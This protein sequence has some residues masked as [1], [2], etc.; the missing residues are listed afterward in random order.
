MVGISRVQVRGAIG[1][2]R[3]GNIAARGYAIADSRAVVRSLFLSSAVRMELLPTLRRGR[4]FDELVALTGSVRPERLQAWLDIGVVLGELGKRDGCY[5]IRGRRARAIA[6]GDALLRAHY[7][8]MLDYQVG[9]YADLASLLQSGVGEGRADLDEYADDIARVSQAATPFLASYVT[10]LIGDERPAR[11]LDVGCGTAI[12]ST[13]AVAADPCVRV[14]GIDLSEGVIESARADL[15]R[16]GLETRI[17]LHAG[18]IR[19]WTPPPSTRY[20]IILLLNNIYYFP[21]DERAALYR[22]LGGLLSGNG[23][24]VVATL[25]AP[26]SIAAAHLNFMLVCQA[27]H[28]ALPRHRELETDLA[29]AGYLVTGSQLIVPTEPFVAVTAQWNRS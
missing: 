7:R 5:R 11:V 17:R 9:P 2:L 28:A 29:A 14:D 26:G 27:G 1:A 19:S 16:A 20:D 6:G 4:T 8:S 3:G 15:H 24:L 13:I 10:R 12:Y 25:T 21:R 18:D 22:R 23:T